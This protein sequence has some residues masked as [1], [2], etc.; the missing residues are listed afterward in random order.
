MMNE[1]R[2]G[3]IAYLLKEREREREREGRETGAEDIIPGEEW[4]KIRH[5]WRRPE[6]FLHH[7]SYRHEFPNFPPRIRSR[8]KSTG[9]RSR[10]RSVEVERRRKLS[11]K[12]V[13][14]VESE[15]KQKSWLVPPL[16]HTA[17]SQFYRKAQSRQSKKA[18]KKAAVAQ[19]LN[20]SGESGLDS[21]QVSRPGS[22]SG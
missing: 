4:E 2:V 18:E 8:K 12:E 7:P 21:P 19:R 16:P 3:K 1:T 11:G 13:E 14:A 9:E 20:T 10:A 17:V 22:P 5:Q 15:N 6:D